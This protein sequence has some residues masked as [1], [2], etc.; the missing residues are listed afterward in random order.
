MFLDLTGP[1][2]GD[3]NHAF[4]LEA[5]PAHLIAADPARV[6]GGVNPGDKLVTVIGIVAAIGAVFPAD[7]GRPRWRPA[8]RASTPSP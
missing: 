8:I 1:R 6:R 3:E 4:A 5:H 2:R 7:A